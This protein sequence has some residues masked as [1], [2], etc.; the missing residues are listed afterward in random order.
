MSINVFIFLAVIFLLFVLAL[1]L[2]NRHHRVDEHE[3]KPKRRDDDE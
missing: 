1:Y 3:I 2:D